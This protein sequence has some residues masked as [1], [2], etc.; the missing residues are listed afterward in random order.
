VH[1]F[2]H[3]FRE[4]L[5]EP[6]GSERLADAIAENPPIEHPLVRTHPE[7]GAKSLY[8]N[9]LFTT[10]IPQLTHKES[11]A[12]LSFLFR[13]IVTEEHTVRLQWQPGT[14][15]IWDNRSVQH[16]PVND[17]HPQHRR[18]HRVTICGDRPA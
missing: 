18:M 12:L 3:G 11:E 16:K 1:D 9:A 13:H 2:R 10:R 4:S 7:S 8:V 14:V 17:F 6:G 15:A 5:A